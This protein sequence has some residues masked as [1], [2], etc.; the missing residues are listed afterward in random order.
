M[1]PN[2]TDPVLLFIAKLAKQYP[3]IEKL[4]LFGSRARGDH[5]ER[6]DYDLAVYA[7]HINEQDWLSFSTQTEE[8][9]PSLCKI[10]LVLIDGTQDQKFLERIES[11]GIAL[12]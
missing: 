9:A 2:H 6:S 7:P 8:Q 12:L 10:S 1:S 3:K 5:E 4:K 11:E